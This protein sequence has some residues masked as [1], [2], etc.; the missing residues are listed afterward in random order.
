MT[1]RLSSVLPVLVLLACGLIPLTAAAGPITYTEVFTASGT[2][3]GTPFDG[4]VT[5]TYTSD[6]TLVYECG[7]PIFCTPQGTASF[8][9]QG[10]GAGAFK[11]PFYVFDDQGN[12]VA[13]FA[14]GNVDDIVDLSNPAFA[15][16]DLKSAIGPLSSTYFYVHMG[17]LGSTLGTVIIES[18]SGTPTFAATT[19]G[20]TPEPGSLV[21]FGSGVVGLAAVIRRKLKI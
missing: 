16:Y 1:K 19:S 10:I 20:T 14:D 17:G 4:T 9:I 7:S 13:G 6:T 5:F 15:T 18:V 12:G 2:V 8:S 11:D 21:L 3:N